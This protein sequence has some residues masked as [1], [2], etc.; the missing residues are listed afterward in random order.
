MI[1]AGDRGHAGGR[2]ISV[3][4][5][6]PPLHGL[7]PSTIHS[8]RVLLVKGESTII[9]CLCHIYRVLGCSGV[10]DPVK[11]KRVE[12]CFNGGNRL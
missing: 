10:G 7:H 9:L 3:L 5:D 12:P 1:E 4:R 6:S 2:L 11:N 8:S